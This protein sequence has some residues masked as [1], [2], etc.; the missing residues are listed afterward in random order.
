VQALESFLED[1]LLTGGN[2][3]G[4]FHA[5]TLTRLAAG[6]LNEAVAVAWI[7][8][9]TVPSRRARIPVLAHRQKDSSLSLRVRTS[10]RIARPE[11][12][13]V[14]SPGLCPEDRGFL[15]PERQTTARCPVMMGQHSNQSLMRPLLGLTMPQA[16]RTAWIY[17]VA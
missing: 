16:T 14:D 9:F 3:F 6:R 12:T 17:V 11:D 7:E 1:Q 13:N 5:L 15:R 4:C 2:Q 10:A 8:N